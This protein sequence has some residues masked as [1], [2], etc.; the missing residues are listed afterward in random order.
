MGTILLVEADPN[1]R[2]L[3]QQELEDEGYDVIPA[4][5]CQIAQQKLALHPDLIVLD[6]FM[7][8]QVQYTESVHTLQKIKQIEQ[9][10]PIILYTAQS[11]Y[12][13]DY[14]YW[15]VD[16]CVL[17]SSNLVRLKQTVADLLKRP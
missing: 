3:C 6:P 10:T 17:R 12:E 8:S 16:A 5:N 2:L 1:Q 9:H 13:N 14:R 15:L 4:S 7:S 11:L